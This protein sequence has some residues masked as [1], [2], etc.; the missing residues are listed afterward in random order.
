MHS[1]ALYDH[2]ESAALFSE[3]LVFARDRGLLLWA[4]EQKRRLA[5]GLDHYNDMRTCIK[6]VKA[7]LQRKI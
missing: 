5:V 4:D 3:C 2:F 1:C 7:R 6:E